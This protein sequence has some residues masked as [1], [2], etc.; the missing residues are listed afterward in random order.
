M[1][2]RRFVTLLGGAAAVPPVIWPLVTRAQ[3]PNKKR[4]IGVLMNLTADDPVSAA[5]SAAFAQGLERLGWTV[6]GN[7]EIDYRWGAGSLER[8]RGHATE[9]VALA[10]DVILAAGALAVGPLQ[11]ASRTVPI[12]FVATTDPV[13]AG[14][15]ASMARPGSNAT[16][17][18]LFEYGISAKWLELLKQIVPGMTRAAVFRDSTLMASMSQFAAIQSVAHSFGVDLFPID[19][20][21]PSEIE[22]AVAA[23]ATKPDGGLMVVT[24]SSAIVHREQIIKLAAR[25]R[26]P[27]VYP[28]R[29]YAVAG[30]LMSYGP[31]VIDQF[32]SAAGYV[33]R[34][35][36]GEK[37]ADL[38]VQAPTRYE[39]VLNLK[40]AKAL[41]LEVPPSILVR[42]NEV[43][44]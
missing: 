1:K 34:I 23:F 26:L 32:R 25:H 38:P 15:V 35:L 21:D 33:D 31:N 43:I 5:R 8:I 10:P 20:R 44:E 2:R 13:G 3:S 40:T 9:L 36:R 6:G 17:F 19:T 42:A 24:G 7:V 41:G 14:F 39:T 16:G 12:V 28:Y 11:Q 29:L 18:T 27:G 37:P 30:G 22:R 4:R